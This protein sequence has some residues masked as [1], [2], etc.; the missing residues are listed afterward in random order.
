MNDLVENAIKAI[1][2]KQPQQAR[3]LLYRALLQNNDD[4]DAWTWLAEVAADDRERAKCLRA[5]IRLEPGNTL[6]ARNLEVLTRN[7]I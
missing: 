3:S 6:A 7:N 4:L 1:K 2:N 5:I